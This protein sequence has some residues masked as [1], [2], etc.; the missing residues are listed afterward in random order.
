MPSMVPLLK[1]ALLEHVR[2]QQ[3]QPT[4]RIC[5]IVMIM[6]N[7]SLESKVPILLNHSVIVPEC[8]EPALVSPDAGEDRE[9]VRLEGEEPAL[10]AELGRREGSFCK[11]ETG[12]SYTR[13]RITDHIQSFRSVRNFILV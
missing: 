13:I 4:M 7:L 11:L 5:L 6:I 1:L 9:V 8:S 12:F 3:K 2:W 10:G